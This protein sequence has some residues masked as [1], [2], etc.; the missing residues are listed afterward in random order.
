[1]FI[2]SGKSSAVPRV[3]ALPAMSWF[4]HGTRDV[5][6]NEYGYMRGTIPFLFPYFLNSGSFVHPRANYTGTT[7]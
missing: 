1:M 6:S 7:V 2:L 5:C 3:D 4:L